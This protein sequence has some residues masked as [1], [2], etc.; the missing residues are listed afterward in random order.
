MRAPA[1]AVAAALVLTG[2]GPSSAP[3]RGRV[4]FARF[5]PGDELH[6]FRERA[7]GS[8]RVRL[9]YGPGSYDEPQW[10]ADGRRIAASGGPGLV[11]LAPDGRIVRRIRVRGGGSTPH[12]SP[13]ARRIAYL[14][15]SCMDPDS[16]ED[17]G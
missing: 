16:H 5:T 13:D 9:T 17:P 10:S 7:T 12:W 14:V 4:V 11:V 3:L 8:G 2:A 6:L 1:L 15:L